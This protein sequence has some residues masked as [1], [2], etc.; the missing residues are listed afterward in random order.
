ML[1]IKEIENYKKYG[2]CLSISNGSIEALVTL[3]VGPRIISFS[4]VGQDN[5]L[6]SEREEFEQMG[7]KEFDE[8]Y[9]KGAQWE[10]YGGHRLW[11]APESLPETYYP[12]NLPV[13]YTIDGNSVLFKQKPQKE[14]GI[15]ISIEV[16]MDNKKPEMSV[17]H[18]GKN[19]SDGQ[20]EFALWPITVMDKGGIEIIPLNCD[21]TG[22]LPN[23][24]ITFWPYTNINDPRFY[25][26]NKY[27]TLSQDASNSNAFKIG[28]DCHSGIGYY[29]IGDNVFC[30]EYTHAIGGNYPDYSA[31]YE[32]YTNETILEFETLSTI[33]NV[34]PSETITHSEKWKLYSK[35][36][37]L[38]PK[39]EES[40][41]KFISSLVS[42]K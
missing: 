35:P 23:R 7:G 1:K 41:S 38:D 39:N 36:C 15:E 6:F 11:I 9:Y 2:K 40:I 14:N 10:N 3:E 8:H 33:H 16:I 17:K 18:Y 27:I 30:K 12:D 29:V 42:E 19:I 28:V 13:E 32:S 24:N 31:S 5:I 21:D 26:C 4:F 25:I 37:E 22:L 20:K 34:N